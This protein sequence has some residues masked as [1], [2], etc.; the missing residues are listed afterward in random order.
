MLMTSSVHLRLHCSS[1]VKE[2][3]EMRFR[4]MYA[5]DGRDV[6]RQ[7]MKSAIIGPSFRRIATAGGMQRPRP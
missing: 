1:Y 6:E 4:Q 7:S 3:E 5:T 2:L